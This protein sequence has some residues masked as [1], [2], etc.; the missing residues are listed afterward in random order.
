[1]VPDSRLCGKNKT[2]TG[3]ITGIVLTHSVR[4]QPRSTLYG[5]A[6][7]L[8]LR[9]QEEVRYPGPGYPAYG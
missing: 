8:S 1:M 7:F 2:R 9:V 4:K 6:G 5:K 3:I